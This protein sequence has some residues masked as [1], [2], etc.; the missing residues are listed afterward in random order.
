MR[1]ASVVLAVAAAV[2]ASACADPV[3]SSLSA[4]VAVSAARDASTPQNFQTHL[5][6]DA[7][8]PARPTL[9]QGNAKFQLSKD[10]Q[11]IEYRII[12]SNIENAFMAHIH[13]GAPTANGGIVVWLRPTSPNP[14]PAPETQ[15]RHDGVFAEGTFTSA[16]FVGALANQPMSAL[17]AQIRAGNAYVN[18]HTRDLSLPATQ[19]QPGNYPGGEVRGQIDHGNGMH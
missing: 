11:S 18:V 6:G 14:V 2:S 9:A 15:A 4:A 10:G 1:R 19:L 16:N 8:N 5:D 13:L 17:L 7:E 12:A 3:G